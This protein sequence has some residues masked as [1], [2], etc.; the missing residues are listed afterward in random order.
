MLSPGR[1]KTGGFIDG[2][3]ENDCDYIEEVEKYFFNS[4]NMKIQ[5]SMQTQLHI[6]DCP[7]CNQRYKELYFASLGR[8]INSSWGEK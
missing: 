2:E 5:D 7:C 1:E 4:A 8:R 6:F 3:N